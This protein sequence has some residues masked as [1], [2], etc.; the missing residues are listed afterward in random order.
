[1]PSLCGGHGPVARPRCLQVYNAYGET[2]EWYQSGGD[3]SAQSPPPWNTTLP[4]S[5]PNRPYLE[6]GL[7]GFKEGTVSPPGRAMRSIH[8][9]VRVLQSF[10]LLSPAQRLARLGHRTAGLLTQKMLIKPTLSR[11]HVCWMNQYVQAVKETSRNPAAPAQQMEWSPGTSLTAWHLLT[12]LRE[13][14]RLLG[15]SLN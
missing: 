2:V 12:S 6:M 5:H 13:G 7:S 14:T 1:M 10:L 3:T 11:T 15:Q 9:H 4:N 8:G